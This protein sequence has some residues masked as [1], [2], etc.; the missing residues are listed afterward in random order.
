M[1]NFP[2]SGRSSGGA[3]TE[4]SPGEAAGIEAKGFS[5]GIVLESVNQE[6]PR[7]NNQYNGPRSE[8][9][10]FPLDGGENFFL[11]IIHRRIWIH[12]TRSPDLPSTLPEKELWHK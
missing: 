10:L 5:M 4:G 8:I 9:L 6:E 3:V 2:C 1:L 12:L 11:G 7:L